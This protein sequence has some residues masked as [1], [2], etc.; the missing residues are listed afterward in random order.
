MGN[1]VEEMKNSSLVELA[2]TC[3]GRIEGFCSRMWILNVEKMETKQV[4]PKK[5]QRKAVARM[6]KK[7]NKTKYDK[8]V[9]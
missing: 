4:I 7:Q 1:A 5:A 9:K 2:N 3:D 6:K 8:R